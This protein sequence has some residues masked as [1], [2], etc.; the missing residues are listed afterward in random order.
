[1]A[2]TLGLLSLCAA[3]LA[4]GGSARSQ[5]GQASV[6]TVI[7]AFSSDGRPEL[8]PQGGPSTESQ[9]GRRH[10]WDIWWSYNREY[11]LAQRARGRPVTGVHKLDDKKQRADLRESRLYDVMLEAL[12][13]KD[14]DVRSSAAVALGKFG[15]SKGVRTPLERHINFPPEGWPDVREG[16]IYGTGLLSL[17]ENR[18]FLDTIA[19]DKD[20]PVREQ[21]IA[22]T[23]LM[24]DGSKESA[25]TLVWH[26][27]Y[28]RS[29][30]KAGPEGAPLRAEQER[31][32]FAT[33]LLGF[34]E[35]PGYDDFLFQVMRGGRGWEE[36][37]QA[38]AVTA[39]GRRRAMDYK[40]P[41]FKL[42]YDKTD[43]NVARS[44]AIALGMMLEHGDTEDLKRLARF[45]RDSRADTIAQN[46]AVMALGQIGG[47]TAVELLR[48]LLRVFGDEEARAFVYLALGLCGVHS[49][50]AR[51]ILLNEYQ[52][53]DTDVEQSVLA[54]ACGI[55]KV[56][57]AVPIT[58]E[59]LENPRKRDTSGL[60]AR[61]RFAGW[62]CLAL[63][64]HDDGRGLPAVRN[65]LARSNDAFVKEQAA[66]AVSLLQ[67]SASVGEL[68][69]ILKDAGTLH[70]KAAVVIALGVL[71]EP[72]PAAVDA[73]VK[74]YKDDSM[75][76]TV[77]ALAICALGA[78]ADP[79]PVPVSALLVRN[80]NYFI[81]CQALDEIATYL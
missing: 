2:R 37:E 54:L 46:F 47:E 10:T 69:D 60:G 79:R 27:R 70:A 56:R 38:L 78:L 6:H 41:I 49:A 57:E 14:K 58:I 15:L 34:V 51:E 48:D 7:V 40:E 31:R 32:R 35:E 25:D 77:R 45:V 55:A 53:A 9:R 3:A 12:E 66:I 42:L 76:N 20:R 23:G 4:H 61:G 19:Q 80:Y 13:D 44:A 59:A 22:L 43:R 63:G 50:A 73:L 5:Q 28:V 24:M 81:R 21:S 65:V 1:M 52:R 11:Y 64:F 67:R 36:G 8:G 33:H 75:P 18:R 39:L 72:T 62:A 71:P 26:A 74:I 29:G 30:V 68:M 17:G 16:S